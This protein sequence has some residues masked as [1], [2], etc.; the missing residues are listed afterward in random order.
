MNAANEQA[1]HSAFGSA[2]TGENWCESQP[3]RKNPSEESIPLSSVVERCSWEFHFP[4]LY[5]ELFQFR[6]LKV[7]NLWQQID[8]T[9]S[10]T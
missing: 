9:E 7:T 8:K 1:L 10:V 5:V 4:G 2:R 3:V 6:L